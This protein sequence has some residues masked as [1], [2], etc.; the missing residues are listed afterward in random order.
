L[1]LTK[2]FVSGRV[3]GSSSDVQ[4]ELSQQV[5]QISEQHQKQLANLR[6]EI[7]AKETQIEIIK[8]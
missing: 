6:D 2:N 8:E 7:R 1:K 3:A 4:K 5:E